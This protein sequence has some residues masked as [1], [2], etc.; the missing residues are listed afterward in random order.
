MKHL[1]ILLFS[2]SL[3]PTVAHAEDE[4]QEG[5]LTHY[6][7]RALDKGMGKADSLQQGRRK[8]EFGRH[9]TDWVSAPQ[10]GG[11]I[12]GKYGYTDSRNADISNGFEVRLVRAY[13]SGTVL[14][15]F[16]YRIQLELRNTPAMRDYTL[17]WV[18]WKEFQ[19]KVG[20]F[21]R[22]FTFENPANPWDIGF[23]GYS[24]LAMHMC[25][26]GAEDPSGEASQNGRDQGLQLQGDLFPLGKDRHRLLHYKA[27]VYNGSGQN[28][29]DNNSKKDFMGCLQVQPVRDFVIAAFGWTGSYRIGDV[30]VK[31]DRWGISSQFERKDWTVRAEYAHHTGHNANKYDAAAMSFTDAGKSDAW[32]ATVGIPATKWLKTY[33]KYDVWRR[34]ADW[35]SS[36]TVYSICPNIQLHRNLKFQLQYNFVCDKTAADRY[37]NELWAQTYVR[38]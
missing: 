18:H 22:C 38:F 34:D 37:Y 32:Y 14:K 36:R 31:R 9:V 25:A 33:L 16:R 19:V 35:S 29:S 12:V 4:Y 1:Y 6:L 3:L 17:E 13:V 2:L 23:G 21:K 28:K 10:F 15:D 7:N 8:M 24:Q 20:Q 26:F 11:Y 5:F 30:E 27:A